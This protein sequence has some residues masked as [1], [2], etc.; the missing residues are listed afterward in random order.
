MLTTPH[1]TQVPLT[2]KEVVIDIIDTLR[3]K[4][5]AA[6]YRSL[7]V[8]GKSPGRIQGLGPSYGT[9][10][11]YFAGFRHG[12]EPRPLIYDANVAKAIQKE[13]TAPNL[14]LNPD[15]LTTAQYVSYCEWCEQV[16]TDY[17]VSSRS[18]IVEL[19]LFRI[20]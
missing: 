19:A 14:P 5:L 7:F 10:F 17:S 2:V 6:G 12:G 16:A 9:K 15:S 20:R 8:A 3:I 11:L 18:D 13:P 1:P 4:G